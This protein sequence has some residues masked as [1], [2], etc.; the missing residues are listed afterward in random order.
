M[1]L[2]SVI[3]PASFKTRLS[4]MLQAKVVEPT[5]KLRFGGLYDNQTSLIKYMPYKRDLDYTLPN[6]TGKDSSKNIPPVEYWLGYGKTEAEYIQSG[7]DDVKKMNDN[8]IAS[9]YSERNNQKVLDL[10]C[11]CA[12][13]LRNMNQHFNDSELW[14][15]DIDAKLIYWCKQNIGDT[16]NYA[17]TTLIP[18]LPFESNYFN[19][20]YCGSVFTHIDDLAEAWLLEVRRVLKIGGVFYV[21]IHDENTVKMLGTDYRQSNLSNHL[22]Q[23]AT[24]LKNKENFGMMVIDRDN[25][26]QVFFSKAYFTQWVQPF[27]EVLQI[28]DGAYGYQSVAVLR[29]K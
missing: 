7:I 20:I 29:K 5:L 6:I 13:M 28:I 11:G 10:G 21:T 8:L 12:R 25:L 19:L 27:F 15:L 1:G 9:G 26:S 24:Y 4:K 3:I 18:H 22:H 17:T 2:L 14:G 23:N 16:A